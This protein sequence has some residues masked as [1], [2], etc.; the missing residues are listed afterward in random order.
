MEAMN[1]T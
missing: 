1:G